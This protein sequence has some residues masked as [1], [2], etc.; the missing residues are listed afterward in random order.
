MDIKT[1]IEQGHKDRSLHIVFPSELEIDILFPTMNDIITGSKVLDIVSLG[2]I[3]PDGKIQLP[4][5]ELLK[6]VREILHLVKLPE[7]LTLDDLSAD[8]YGHL[9]SVI[10]DFFTQHQFLTGLKNTQE[11]SSK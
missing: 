7:P 11:A 3:T 4:E 8:D 5:G 6:V 9:M 2:S 10:S 1:Y